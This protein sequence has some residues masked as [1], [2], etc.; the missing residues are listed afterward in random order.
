MDRRQFLTAAA[1]VTA[2]QA[3]AADAEPRLKL[4]ATEHGLQALY[5]EQPVFTYQRDP[6]PGPS[7][8]KPLFARGA[9]IHPLYAPNGAVVTD[10]FPSDHLHQRGVF[11][12]WTKTQI[13]DLHPDF[14]N[15]GDGLGRIR[16]EDARDQRDIPGFDADHIWEMHEGEKWTP[17]MREHWRVR[18]RP[19]TWKDPQAPDGFFSFDL[20]SRQTPLVD[21]LL[22][23]YRYGGM[24][25]R[26]A[27]QWLTDRSG[28]RC[29][30]S[31]G[32]DLATADATR[33]R[34]VDLSGP[35]GE[36]TAGFSLLEHPANLGA[37]NILRVPPDHPYACFSPPKA[38]ALKLEAR[39]EYVF[40]YRILAHNGPARPEA[41]EAEWKRF[42]G[43]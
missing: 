36:K 12:A 37:P 23:E 25:I 43:A 24:A 13:G 3:F 18:L 33:A 17:V 9:Y 40:R 21:I 31:E 5:G 19:P 26:G 28:L 10:D 6:Q 15:I 4:K 27:R 41:L 16:A 32:Q 1:A 2:S 34:W 11:F 22:P 8:T 42:S 14:W 29:V 30:T 39:K 20:I 35:I 7:G 38:R